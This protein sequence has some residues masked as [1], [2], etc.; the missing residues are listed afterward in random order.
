MEQF[1]SDYH[2]D[3]LF[4]KTFLSNIPYGQ[5]K[6]WLLS[7]GTAKAYAAIAYLNL[8]S[9]NNNNIEGKKYLDK[10]FE[11]DPNCPEAINVW[12]ENN[13]FTN[14]NTIKKMQRYILNAI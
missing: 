1:I 5:A 7:Q 4:S 8:Y 10:A 2:H 14:S 6:A 12:L 3:K 9:N 13:T 11:L